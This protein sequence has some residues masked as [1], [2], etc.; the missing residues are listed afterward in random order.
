MPQ[1]QVGEKSVDAAI[2]LIEAAAHLSH[3][4]K[5]LPS[6]ASLAAEVA[7]SGLQYD[8]NTTVK[9]ASAKYELVKRA[10]RSKRKIMFTAMGPAVA[11]GVTALAGGPVTMVVVGGALAAAAIGVGFKKAWRNARAKYYEGY[12][13]KSGDRWVFAD[14]A[15]ALNGVRYVLNKKKIS[16]ISDDLK[17]VF[18]A[19]QEYEKRRGK[20]VTSCREASELAYWYYRV[21]DLS[22]RLGEHFACFE[23][24][25]DFVIDKLDRVMRT[26]TAEAPAMTDANLEKALV[27]AHNWVV[28]AKE[29]HEAQK[30]TSRTD[31]GDKKR[32]FPHDCCFAQDTSGKAIS[33]MVSTSTTLSFMLRKP[34]VRLINDAAYRND[35]GESMAMASYT[36]ERGATQRR[37]EG[38][39][40]MELQTIDGNATAKALDTTKIVWDKLHL[41]TPE[42]LG[43]PQRRDRQA[44]PPPLK[45]IEQQMR[46]RSAPTPIEELLAEPSPPPRA[47]ASLLASGSSS[48]AERPSLLEKGSHRPKAESDESVGPRAAARTAAA[49]VGSSV[50]FGTAQVQTVALQGSSQVMPTMAANAIVT[51][52]TSGAGIALAVIAAFAESQN[53]KNENTALREELAKADFTKV[54]VERVLT[55]LRTMLKDGGAF[56]SGINEAAKIIEYGKEWRKAM[57]CVDKDMHCAAAYELVYRPLK[58]VK[59]LGELNKYLPILSL[60]ASI[61]KALS[62]QADFYE[63]VD[64]MYIFETVKAWTDE[65]D[66]S[67]C[68]TKDGKPDI[69][70]VP[71]ADEEE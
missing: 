17:E 9:A 65:G 22:E 51:G 48:S 52:S 38:T 70:Y 62:E 14:D 42:R 24:F 31:S 21:G 5:A 3:Q 36:D 15:A 7:K 64:A 30:C 66:H 1:F 43:L 12:L 10:D 45:S 33:P 13:K 4:G 41:L 46:E 37:L 56:E 6:G 68:K 23:Q 40:I 57:A 11:I 53:M 27:A 34:F 61:A 8:P 28:K 2:V 59:H 19:I 63:G 44:P 49:L 60:Y 29:Q 47:S 35:H 20:E 71:E 25:Y 39:S 67:A 26:G 55:A 16:K 32:V 50:G 58:T 69:C 18:V 54:N